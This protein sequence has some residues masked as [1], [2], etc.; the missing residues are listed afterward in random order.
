MLPAK[1]GQIILPS[2]LKKHIFAFQRN[3]VNSYNPT[4]VYSFVI[5]YSNNFAKL[6]STCIYIITYDWL[7]HVDITPS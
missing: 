6:V 5:P 4:I 3:W 7:P 2:I 1:E